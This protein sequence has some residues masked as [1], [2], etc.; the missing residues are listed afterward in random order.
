MHDI[1]PSLPGP[2]GPT[3][4]TDIKT[5]QILSS[6]V[7]VNVAKEAHFLGLYDVPCTFVGGKNIARL[8]LPADIRTLPVEHV[9]SIVCADCGEAGTAKHDR[10]GQ[11]CDK[12]LFTISEDKT[13]ATIDCG[14]QFICDNRKHKH[15][16]NFAATH[17]PKEASLTFWLKTV[18]EPDDADEIA[19]CP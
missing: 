13:S 2:P 7:F 10:D 14:V 3:V 4:I 6:G 17:P 12:A 9:T 19:P 15:C 16:P 8:K 11:Q 18:E 5:T 1:Y